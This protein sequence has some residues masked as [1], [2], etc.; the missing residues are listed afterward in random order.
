MSQT[1]HKKTHFMAIRISSVDKA[2]FEAAARKYGLSL[3]AWLRMIATANSQSAA[4]SA[5]PPTEGTRSQPVG[6]T[7][8]T[9]SQRTL[10]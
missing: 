9:D 1:F 6:T 10:A 2:T 3:S 5:N 8:S 7:V 4:V